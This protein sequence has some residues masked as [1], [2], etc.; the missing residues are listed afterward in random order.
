M[1]TEEMNP[2]RMEEEAATKG[3]IGGGSGG[4]TKSEMMSE[5]RIMIQ[6]LMGLGLKL[7]ELEGRL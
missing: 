1:S 6:E 4:I 7:Y 2:K 3:T 5:T